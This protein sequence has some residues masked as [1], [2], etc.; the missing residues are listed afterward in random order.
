MHFQN[1]RSPNGV[2][3]AYVIQGGFDSQQ[4]LE[5]NQGERQVDYILVEEGQSTQDAKQEVSPFFFFWLWTH[6]N[7]NVIPEGFDCYFQQGSKGG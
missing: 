6:L 1:V 7:A 4:F 2:K 5:Q 3:L